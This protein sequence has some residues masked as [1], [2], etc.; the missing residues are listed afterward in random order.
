MA[1]ERDPPDK[2]NTREKSP[3][4]SRISP[5]VAGNGEVAV[6][7][8]DDATVVLFLAGVGGEDADESG[9]LDDLVGPPGRVPQEQRDKLGYRQK[10]SKRTWP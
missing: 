7:S 5:W 6:D 4:D 3:D 2:F 8:H 1:T 10:G 9:A